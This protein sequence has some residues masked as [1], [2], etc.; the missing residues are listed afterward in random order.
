[1][2]KQLDRLDRQWS[3]LDPQSRATKLNRID[4]QVTELLLHAEKDCRKLRTGEVDFSPEVSTAADK[5][6]LWRVALKVALGKYSLL[7]E[8][9]CICS[10]LRVSLPSLNNV[11]FIKSNVEQCK[12]AHIKLKGEHVFHGK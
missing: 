11:P 5:W 3:Q 6:Y 4:Q 12:A 9:K 1:M 7:P 2:P 8:L 10:K